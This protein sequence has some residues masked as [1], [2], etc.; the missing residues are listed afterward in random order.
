MK[1]TSWT[2]VSQND[3]EIFFPFNS[4]SLKFSI[5]VFVDSMFL[6]DFQNNYRLYFPTPNSPTKTILI[7][8]ES[9][10][11]VVIINIFSFRNFYM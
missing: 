8:N 4:M 9:V 2:A 5:R 3:I 7:V 1:N 11:D 6:M 10:F